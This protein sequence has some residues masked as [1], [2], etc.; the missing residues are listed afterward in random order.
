AGMTVENASP[1]IICPSRQRR[2]KIM[3]VFIFFFY[4]LNFPSPRPSLDALL[5][6]DRFT[7]VIVNFIINQPVDFI[8]VCKAR[9]GICSMFIDAAHEVVGNTD[10]DRSATTACENVEIVWH[11]KRTQLSSR[12]SAARAGTH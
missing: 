9:N 10:V 4:Q 8:V 11:S 5:S 3:P 6:C 2:P 12:P 1:P 7:N